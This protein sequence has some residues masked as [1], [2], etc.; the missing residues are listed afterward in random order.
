MIMLFELLSGIMENQLIVSCALLLIVSISAS[1]L[2]G[3]MVKRGENGSRFWRKM[4]V[5][6]SV[7]CKAVIIAVAVTAVILI[8]FLVVILIA[9]PFIYIN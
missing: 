4:S 1:L 9:F 7:S 3:V 5:L 6:F 2:Y 8:I